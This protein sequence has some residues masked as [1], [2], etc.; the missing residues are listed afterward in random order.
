M[1]KLGQFSSITFDSFY[2]TPWGARHLGHR[3]Y[4]HKKDSVKDGK[5]LGGLVAEK[6]ERDFSNFDA[7]FFAHELLIASSP[8]LHP[9]KQG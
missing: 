7:G 6:V 1:F 2:I 8:L 4:H 5:V 9:L 3:T